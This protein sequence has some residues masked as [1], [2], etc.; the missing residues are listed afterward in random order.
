M[1]TK[2]FEFYEN[3]YIHTSDLSKKD[4][5]EMIERYTRMFPEN[6]Y[7]SME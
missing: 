3:G 5:E 1:K 7:Y 4:A 2:R 6:E